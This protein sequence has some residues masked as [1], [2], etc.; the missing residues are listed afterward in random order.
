ME[1]KKP[2]RKESARVQGIE[3]VQPFGLSTVSYV[4]KRIAFEQKR[5]STGAARFQ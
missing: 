1:A 4:V 5:I 3:T 2:N